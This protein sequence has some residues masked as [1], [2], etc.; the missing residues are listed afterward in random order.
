MKLV[1]LKQF[2]DEKGITYEAV[3]KQTVKYA[4]EL[5]GHIVTMD[6]TRYL[7]E[8]AQ[9]ILSDRRRQSPIV[10]R[11]ED[12]Q[13]DNEEYT[14][15]IETLKNQL[16]KAQ[17]RVI[18]LQDEARTGIEEK[19]KYQLL[20]GDYEEQKRRLRETEAALIENRS[21]LDSEREM[22]RNL[23]NQTEKQEKQ[24]E[25]LRAEA[26][27]YEKTWFGLYRKK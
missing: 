20:I 2:A 22:R 4:S 10:V 5:E 9:S 27:S 17:E 14:K 19:I 24:I 13:A 16:L 23:Q 6:G 8:E 18:Q 7:D 15:Q 1:T 3:R 26:G 12:T 21:A 11:I 25:D